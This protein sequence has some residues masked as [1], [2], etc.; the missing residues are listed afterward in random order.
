MFRVKRLTIGQTRN[1]IPLVD[2]LPSWEVSILPAKNSDKIINQLVELVETDLVRNF[3]QVVKKLS[4][5]SFTSQAFKKLKYHKFHTKK[6][7]AFD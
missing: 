2:V 5:I 7:C 3:S 4:T 6:V 1:K